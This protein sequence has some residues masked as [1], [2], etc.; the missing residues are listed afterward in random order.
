VLPK[1]VDHAE[2]S[3]YWSLHHFFSH[4]WHHHV[5]FAG[6]QGGHMKL[7]PETLFHLL[8][9]S[10]W[11]TNL[12]I[13]DRNIKCTGLEDIRRPSISINDTL[14]NQRA[15][16]LQTLWHVGMT[17]KWLPPSVRT[18]LDAVKGDLPASKYIGY[19]DVILRDILEQA[20]LLERFLM[21]SFTLLMSS[22]SILEAASIK[23]QAQQGQ[24]ITRLAF[25]YV[26]LSFVTGIFGMNVKEINGSPLPIWVPIASFLIVSV[27]TLGVY[28]LWMCKQASR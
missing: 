23:E 2:L 6:V 21:D 9:S 22:I 12:R 16:L 3:L 24:M 4:P 13:L 14:H 27:C 17:L 7:Q 26:P 1:L 18:E 8:A 19:P 11:A 28:V 15:E 25:L 10:T 5:I 20:S